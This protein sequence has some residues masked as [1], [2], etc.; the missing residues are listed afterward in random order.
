MFTA[1]MNLK[2]AI[3]WVINMERVSMT[4]GNE[5]KGWFYYPMVVVKNTSHHIH[6][7]GLRS[8]HIATKSI[9][10]GIFTRPTIRNALSTQLDISL[11]LTIE[12]ASLRWDWSLQCDNSD[13]CG[14]WKSYPIMKEGDKDSRKEGKNRSYDGKRM[15]V[16]FNHLLF[17]FILMRS[18]L[19]VRM[20][21]DVLQR[22]YN[23]YFPIS[24]SKTCKI[25]SF[26]VFH[27]DFKTNSTRSTSWNEDLSVRKNQ[28]CE[29]FGQI[30]SF[31]RT[32]VSVALNQQ[33]IFSFDQVFMFF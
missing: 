10:S 32:R 9:F 15:F 18:V 30:Q 33:N 26:W 13:I 4:L 16:S 5:L 28:F 1:S 22:A 11:T 12:R 6:S 29:V 25:Q 7:L 24:H 27:F 31:I 8:L 3:N 2:R 23:L 14:S 21:T 17:W 19:L 20:Q